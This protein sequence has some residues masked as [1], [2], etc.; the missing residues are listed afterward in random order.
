MTGFGN[1]ILIKRQR[2]CFMYKF[3]RS[4][5]LF[6]ILTVCALIFPTGALASSFQPDIPCKAAVLKEAISGKILYEKNKD[7]KMSPASITKIMSLLIAG[8]ALEDGKINLDDK[9]TASKE[10]SSMGGSQIW[11][12]EN[13]VMTVD[14][15]LKAASVASA[16]DATVALGEHIAGS[17]ESFVALMNERAE[18]L[19]LKNTQFKNCTGLDEEGHFTTAED[20]SIVAEEVLKH[21]LILKYTSIW[22]DELRGGKTKLV[23]TNKLVRFYKGATGLKTGTTD[24]A[25]CCLCAT[26]ERDNL[27][28]IAVSLGSESSKERFLSCKKLLD[29]GFANYKAI[30]SPSLKE[31]LNSV[32]VKKGALRFVGVKAE[33]PEFLV[34]E[35]GK[36]AP[37]KLKIEREEHLQAPVE[38]NTKIGTVEIMQGDDI[39][40][41]ISL[42][43]A[44]PIKELTYTISIKRIFNN[45]FAF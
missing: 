14:E 8:E 34:S 23:N 30:N 32:R 2:S 42:L 21:P 16:N 39:L 43:T 1:K 44:Y 6:C 5:R 29:H 10:A 41:R 22:M 45:I 11:L 35:K 9:V 20:I 17:E 33:C 18:E 40:S 37:L 7:E 4:L 26:A 25:G 13:E 28:L 31:A 38:E 24:K 36:K 19:G 15:L 12:K 27:P 3:K